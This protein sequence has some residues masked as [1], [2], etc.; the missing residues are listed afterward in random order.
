MPR[1][2]R[3]LVV[4]VGL[5]EGKDDEPGPRE[6]CPRHEQQQPAPHARETRLPL[7]TTQHLQSA[8]RDCVIDVFLLDQALWAWL[9]GCGATRTLGK[10][11]RC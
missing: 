2:V 3:V 11:F 5:E 7:V 4:G 9:G 8:T 10:L 6:Q 1:A